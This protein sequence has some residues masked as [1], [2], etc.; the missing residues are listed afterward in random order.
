M[1]SGSG[2]SPAGRYASF[3]ILI[4]DPAEQPALGF[5]GYADALAE[6]VRESPPRFAIGIFG[7][8]GS[9]KTTLMQ[10][11]QS[12]IEGHDDVIPVWFNAWRYE[13]EERMI[14]PLLDVL[15]E[16]LLAWSR[17]VATEKKSVAD[18]GRKAAAAMGA[19]ARA[20]AS[21]VS[22][23]ARVP[24]GAA[25]MKWDLAT[26][27]SKTSASAAVGQ[28]ASAYHG[29]FS[30]MSEAVAGFVAAGS[31]RTGPR[32]GLPQRRIVV[33]IDDL[34]R[35][36]PGNALSVLESMKLFFDMPGFVF[37]VGLDQAIIEAAVESRYVGRDGSPGQATGV[38][39]PA[40]TGS[41]AHSADR[42]GVVSGRDYIKKIFQVPFALPPVDGS[43][44]D[45]L[46]RALVDANE[47]VQDQE[48]D[49]RER[50][51]GHLA[52]YSDTS[53]INPR[54]VKRLINAY[55]LQA[56]LVSRKLESKPIN[57]DAIL[58]IQVITFRRNWD[59]LWKELET[60]ADWFVSKLK[61][62]LSKAKE[63]GDEVAWRGAQPIPPRFVEYVTKGPGKALLTTDD[64]PTYV[65]SSQLGQTT[66]PRILTALEIVEDLA[67]YMR[68]LDADPEQ[69]GLSASLKEKLVEWARNAEGAGWSREVEDQVK[70]LGEEAEVSAM[71]TPQRPMRQW[72]ENYRALIVA[73][74]NTL[75]VIR[76]DRYSLREP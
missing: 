33:F 34:D 2:A 46:V 37:V 5:E 13:R 53:A 50:V 49:L 76:R 20:V 67:R 29:S 36:L 74:Q 56:K 60:D 69:E 68:E 17:K 25:E 24:G 14:V 19:A 7:S 3:Q 22:L 23:S 16:T 41:A 12:R 42:G 21:G 10:G 63:K 8:W 66:E 52:Y 58:T 72:I 64:L 45:D 73:L 15:R 44:V 1:A 75:W 27:L 32:K 59:S 54:E 47:L 70:R 57:L 11:I 31:P 55:T 65:S 30:L 61:N 51:P 9:G 48:D 28:H 38:D 35:C 18:K 4:D 26:V 62:A 39:E 43:L 71:Q 6:I 40:G